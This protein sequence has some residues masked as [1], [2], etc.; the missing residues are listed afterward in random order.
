LWG[1][2]KEAEEEIAMRCAEA[3]LSYVVDKTKHI[4]Q[5]ELVAVVESSKEKEVLP[6]LKKGGTITRVSMRWY[7][8]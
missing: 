6:W 1:E 4:D 2:I 8:Y 3:S 5:N 7:R